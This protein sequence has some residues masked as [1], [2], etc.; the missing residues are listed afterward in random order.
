MY[1]FPI[2]QVVDSAFNSKISSLSESV[3]YEFTLAPLPSD[4]NVLGIML[5][6]NYL[7]RFYLE[8]TEVINTFFTPQE[9]KQLQQFSKTSRQSQWLIGRFLGKKTIQQLISS[10]ASIDIPLQ[11]V[12]FYQNQGLKPVCQINSTQSLPSFDFSIS[13]KKPVFIAGA[14]SLKIGIDVEQQQSFSDRLIQKLFTDSDIAIMVSFLLS[15]KLKFSQNLL[16]TCLWSCKEAV[17]KALGIGLQIDF[18]TLQIVH[19]DGKLFIKTPKYNLFR[20]YI[21][22]LDDY[23]IALTHLYLRNQS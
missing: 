22:L 11:N 4:L 18:Q 10:I 5:K 8:N 1:F 21:A 15:T 20:V 14:A 2:L 3:W 23:I 19:K 12:V 13:H 16:F 7:D 9:L 17:A 6:E